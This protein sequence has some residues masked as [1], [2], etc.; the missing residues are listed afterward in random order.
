[1]FSDISLPKALVHTEELDPSKELFQKW[2]DRHQ[3]WHDQ[4]LSNY[5][6]PCAIVDTVAL[7]KKLWHDDG[8]CWMIAPESVVYEFSHSR[9]IYV[10]RLENAPPDRCYYKITHR[11]P[12]GSSERALTI[13][14]EKLT[15]YLIDLRFDIPF[16]E[17]WQSP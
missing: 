4:W 6:R 17:V 10:S 1:M 9:P 11:A 15:Q 13:F 3:L 2:D 8:D 5:A 16:G 14:E 7:I 12:L